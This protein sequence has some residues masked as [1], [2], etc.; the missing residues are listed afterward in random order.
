MGNDVYGHN[1]DESFEDYRPNIIALP[2]NDV[3]FNDTNTTWKYIGRDVKEL[4]N[5]IC[6]EPN[7]AN[8]DLNAHQ[9]MPEVKFWNTKILTNR[10]L[11]LTSQQLEFLYYI[12]PDGVIDYLTF[13]TD[14][15]VTYRSASLRN[16]VYKRLTGKEIEYY[17]KTIFGWEPTDKTSGDGVWSNADMALTWNR[18][19]SLAD[20]ATLGIA[21]GTILIA[22]PEVAMFIEGVQAF[23]FYNAL[24]AY[25]YGVLGSQ[26]ASWRFL[27]Q[28]QNRG[29]ISDYGIEHIFFGTVFKGK[30]S[31]YHYEG[32]SSNATI[33]AG[34]IS[35]VD[36]YGVYRGK[37]L[38]DGIVKKTNGGFSTFFP[39]NWTPQQVVN[40]IKE[41]FV[42]KQLITGSTNMYQGVT[43]SGMKIEL[44]LDQNGLIKS[45]YPLYNP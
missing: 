33:E 4:L 44:M 12:D 32:I 14:D 30:A 22:L 45:A 29:D 9:Q 13:C 41:A 8:G 37:V 19:I 3:L 23:G 40:A 31:G 11:T 18:P 27:T 39:K 35:E 16:E 7:L 28:L 34:T 21:V 38:V 24:T 1:Q 6:S 43:N 26:L 5:I 20:I 36:A 42:N 15:N 17:K 25:S 10:H 2:N